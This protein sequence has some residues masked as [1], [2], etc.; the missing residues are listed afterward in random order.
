MRGVHPQPAIGVRCRTAS[1]ADRHW[2]PP[3]PRV[4]HVL[5]LPECGRRYAQREG[6]SLTERWGGALS[7]VLY[8][9]I[10]TTRPQER[11]AFNA[12]QLDHIDSD[13]LISEIEYEL[14]HPSQ[15]VREI[16]DLPASE[17]DLREF[18]ALVALELRR[19]L[20]GDA[21]QQE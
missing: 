13:W 11:A 8:G 12:A 1:G 3:L 7:L 21:G 5:D 18:L 9:V 20:V 16:L 4:D 14:N 2:I 10:F 19:R 17:E 15:S 6:C